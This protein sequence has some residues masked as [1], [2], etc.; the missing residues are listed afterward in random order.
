M[1]REEVIAEPGFEGLGGPGVA[2]GGSEQLALGVR[3]PAR[4]EGE[5][6]QLAQAVG[7]G[8]FAA[9]WV[10]AD[11]TILVGGRYATDAVGASIDADVCQAMAGQNLGGRDSLSWR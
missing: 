4:T 3:L 11:E 8:G 9:H 7:G 1:L 5:A 2:G 6:Q 10:E